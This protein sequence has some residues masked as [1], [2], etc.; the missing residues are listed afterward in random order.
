MRSYNP[1]KIV[2][3]I[4]VSDNSHYTS[5]VVHFLVASFACSVVGQVADIAAAEPQESGL[6]SLKFRHWTAIFSVSACDRRPRSQ[7]TLRF[8]DR[9]FRA[10]RR[11]RECANARYRG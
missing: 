7:T 8:D 5:N 1:K 2:V 3:R 11:W 6:R 9:E 10:W 4:H